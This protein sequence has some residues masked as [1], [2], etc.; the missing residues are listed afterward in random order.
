MRIADAAKALGVGPAWIRRM[1]RTGA[2]PRATRDRNG[3]RRYTDA[4][5]KAMR[6]LLM[7]RTTTPT[8]EAQ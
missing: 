6:A 4:D 1:E 7:K 5:I 8:E 2:L 3:Q